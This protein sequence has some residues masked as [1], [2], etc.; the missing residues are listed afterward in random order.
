[1]KRSAKVLRPLFVPAVLCVATY[2]MVHV[3]DRYLSPFCMVLS[4][5]PLAAVL[6]PELKS[7]RLL[8]AFLIVTYTGGAVI[9]LCVTDGSTVKAA[10]RTESF[11][12]DPQW[13]LAAALPLYGLQPGDAVAVI[14]DDRPI[15]RCHWAYIS[16]LRIVAE[17]V[18]TLEH[19]SVGPH[20]I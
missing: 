7:K 16:Q 18:G 13:K 11:R 5:L 9:E 19:R 1:M 15:Y 12:R 10:I 14:H 8:L 2:L 20:T 17:L 6:E 4:L 3:E